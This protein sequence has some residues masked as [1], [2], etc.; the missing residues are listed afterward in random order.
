MGAFDG[1]SNIFQE[2]L[3]GCKGIED[4]YK[5]MLKNIAIA[6]DVDYE[7]LNPE[8]EVVVN[9]LLVQGIMY[10]DDTER[11]LLFLRYGLMMETNT[12]A[13]IVGISREEVQ[14]QSLNAKEKLKRM[15][16]G[17]E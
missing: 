6:I 8:T 9:E 5:T 10:L 14:V 13:Q 17:N 1:D 11:E 2:I 7:E 4:F 16:K 15:L 3:S 12:I